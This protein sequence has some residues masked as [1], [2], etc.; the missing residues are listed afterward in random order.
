MQFLVW[1]EKAL[2]CLTRKIRKQPRVRRCLLAVLPCVLVIV[3]FTPQ[4]ITGEI[5]LKTAGEICEDNFANRLW[6]NQAERFDLE[7]FEDAVESL[8]GDANFKLHLTHEFN[9]TAAAVSVIGFLLWA[10]FTTH[11]AHSA[12]RLDQTRMPLP[13]NPSRPLPLFP[14][15]KCPCR[16]SNALLPVGSFHIF[17]VVGNIGVVVSSASMSCASSHTFY[18]TSFLVWQALLFGISI[19]GTNLMCHRYMIEKAKAMSR[20]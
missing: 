9:T 8:N 10:F 5:S 6:E 11:S 17:Q 18:R 12:T 3:W 13:L 16:M 19:M 15:F 4:I 14:F 2:G 7:S 20:M 1:A